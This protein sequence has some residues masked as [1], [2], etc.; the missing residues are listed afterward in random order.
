MWDILLDLM[1]LPEQSVLGVGNDKWDIGEDG[2]YE[3]PLY[4]AVDR[5]ALTVARL[6]PRTSLYL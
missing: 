2:E 6:R 5:T 4:E 3:V 1:I